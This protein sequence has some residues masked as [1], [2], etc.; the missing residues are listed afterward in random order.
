MLIPSNAV[1]QSTFQE[2][3]TPEP[4]QR[5][6]RRFQ[7]SIQPGNGIHGHLM[8]VSDEVPLVR[9]RD[10][11]AI[12]AHVTCTDVLG[13]KLGASVALEGTIITSAME[14]P[15]HGLVAQARMPDHSPE[16]GAYL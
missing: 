3:S 4:A 15:K 5:D 16:A 1:L 11:K 14:Y 2:V 7:G 10:A 12:I 13:R 8:F 9:L 6:L